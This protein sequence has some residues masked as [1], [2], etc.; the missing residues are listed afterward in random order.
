MQGC[1]PSVS[2]RAISVY[3][4]IDFDFEPFELNQV[5]ISNQKIKI[6]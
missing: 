4:P 6:F 2:K 3:I 1:Y 5:V